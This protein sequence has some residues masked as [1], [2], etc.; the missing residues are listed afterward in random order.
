[1][2]DTAVPSAAAIPGGR[3][4]EGMPA[5]APVAAAPSGLTAPYPTLVS[6]SIIDLIVLDHNRLRA[7][8]AGWV[9]PA[10]PFVQPT[11]HLQGARLV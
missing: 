5:A 3:L 2:G 10:G 4:D 11:M 9:L 6:M 8:Y 1:M 7:M